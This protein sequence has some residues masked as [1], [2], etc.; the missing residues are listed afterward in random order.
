MSILERILEVKAVEIAAAKARVPQPAL[1]ARARA[2]S[3]PRD[4]AGALRAR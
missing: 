3:P 1:E 2:V 4:F